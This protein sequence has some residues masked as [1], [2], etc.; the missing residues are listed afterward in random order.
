MAAMVVLGFAAIV[1]RIAPVV[2]EGAPERRADE[3]VIPVP[4]GFQVEEVT[5]ASIGCRDC[6]TQTDAATMHTNPA[7]QIGCAHCHGGDPTVRATGL[8]ANSAEYATAK[9][10]AHVQPQH[11]E[12]WPSTANPKHSYAN[13]LKESPEFVK[14]INP[15]DYRVARE[16]CGG[17]HAK[18]VANAERSLMTT[19]AMLFGG[20][21]YNNNILPYKKY[22]LGERYGR[23][24]IAQTIFPVRAPTDAER[25]RGA[26]DKLMPVPQW[27]VIPPGDIFRVFERGGISIKATFPEIG[28]PNPF[29]ESGKPDIR[30]SNRGP[31]T[32]NRISVPV[33]NLHKTRLNDPHLSLLGTNDH[34]GDYRSSGC[35]GCH[36]VYANDRDPIHSGPYAQFGNEGFTQTVDPTIP[37]NEEGHPLKH[38][39]TRAIPSSQCMVCHMHQP[40]MFVNPYLGY[41]M[42]DYEVDAPKMWPEKQKHPSIKETYDSLLHNPEEAA[43]RGKWTDVNFLK[44]VSE[45][46]ST[47]E[48]T[49]FADYHGHGWNFRAIFSKDR[50]GNLLDKDGKQV[51]W[52]DPHKFKKAVHMRDIHADYGMQCMDCHFE[53]DAHG[54]GNLYGEVAQA[55]EI[56][57]E[58]CH[59]GVKQRATL[60]TTGPASGSSRG[61]R[62]LSLMRTPFGT[63]RFVWRAGQLYQ[64]SSVWPDKE[65]RVKQVRD[66]VDPASKD[67]N[68]QSARAKTMEMLEG[69]QTDGAW[70]NLKKIDAA[71]DDT[72]VLAHAESKMSCFT[73]HS[74]WVTSCAGCHLPI[75]ANWKKT[76][77]HHE[78]KETRN[79]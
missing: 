27:E 48:R 33:I 6:H 7:V 55:V 74:S 17:C 38:E 14:F 56:N 25:A 19:G 44:H 63:L 46:N 40:N 4:M 50:K 67:Y 75:Q 12:S 31:G 60:R 13:L 37:R 53:Q 78:G 71:K 21:A 24:G 39:F 57:C 43:T 11:P 16:T 69:N 51:S 35:A 54:D 2:A 23:D 58:D 66:S 36:V 32:G 70:G 29:D 5:A 45:L 49:Q 47:L 9:S 77:N 62:D 41:T 20:A 34:P 73:C 22:V 18:I 42:W 28:N 10:A 65:W 79:W 52:E 68:P 8:G 1:G 3:S 59:G 76:S 72:K 15:S 61:G 64:R 26:L 30:A